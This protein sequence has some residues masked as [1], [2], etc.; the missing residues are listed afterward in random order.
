MEYRINEQVY[1]NGTIRTNTYPTGII[2]INNL[3]NVFVTNLKGTV[4]HIE[5]PSIINQ[6]QYLFTIKI[7][8]NLY[9]IEVKSNQLSKSFLGVNTNY[10]N[11][12]NPYQKISGPNLNPL[13]NIEQLSQLN[14]LN[15][16]NSQIQVQNLNVNK[17]V[18]KNN[19]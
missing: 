18:Q 13:T 2:G 5:T 12:F 7:F 10:Q 11:P 8:E 16:L 14:K 15:Y 3:K 9:A 6:S 17:N 1:L 19:K 4:H